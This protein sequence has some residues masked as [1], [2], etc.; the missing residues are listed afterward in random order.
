[1]FQLGRR[2]FMVRD[3]LTA[4]SAER[5][6]LEAELSAAHAAL[7]RALQAKAKSAQDNT[8]ALASLLA[9]QAAML[10]QREVQERR[11][12][13][14]A[15]E[16]SLQARTEA[17]GAYARAAAA[18]AMAAQAL[19]QAGRDRQRADEIEQVAR[20]LQMDLST[21]QEAWRGMVA[22]RDRLLGSTMW[23]ATWPLRAVVGLVPFPVR[24]AGRKALKAVWW[25]ATGQLGSRIRQRKRIIEDAA[26]IAA[27]PL[28]DAGW[29]AARYADVQAA[30]TDPALHYASVGGRE[31]RDP[32]PH[33]SAARYMADHP[34]AAASGRSA[35]LHFLECGDQ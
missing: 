20:R 28:F 24:R 6:R 29:Y 18:E 5:S 7:Q 4:A 23:R 16:R 8:E 26:I 35:L 17:S 15:V 31:N 34:A 30:S 19:T 21:A 1:M 27:S 14:V 10:N 32:G 3:E 33:F 12:R 11:V 9:K 13:A 25:T 22:E 2:L